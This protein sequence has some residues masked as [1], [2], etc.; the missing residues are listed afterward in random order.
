VRGVSLLLGTCG[1]IAALLL[2][3]VLGGVIPVPSDGASTAGRLSLAL[4]WLLPS[5]A[6]LWAMVVTQMAARLILGAFDPLAPQGG[7]FLAVNQRVITN[8]VE[9]GL[10]FVP[11]LLALAAGAPAA[12]MPQVLALPVVFVVARCAFWAEYLVTPIGRGPGMA[13]TTAVTT[14]ALGGA[15][16]V[17]L[18]R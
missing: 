16:W 2:W 7:R 5:A 9:Q 10:I 3:R 15:V 14:A 4:M 8:T 6:V 11:A 1:V 17:W 12:A 13:A 18:G